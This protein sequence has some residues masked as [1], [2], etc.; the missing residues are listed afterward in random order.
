MGYLTLDKKLL[1]AEEDE[2]EPGEENS[3]VK[4]LRV[5]VLIPLKTML[6]FENRSEKNAKEETDKSRM[7]LSI[8]VTKIILKFPTDIFVNELQKILSKLGKLLKK[9]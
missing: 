6:M 9:K 5:N 3:I 2:K 8:V 7:F 1:Q 4:F